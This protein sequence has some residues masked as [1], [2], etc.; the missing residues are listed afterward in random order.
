MGAVVF[1]DLCLAVAATAASL[2]L[3]PWRAVGEGGP[4]WSWLAVWA[5][6]PLLWGIDRYAASP[7]AQPM[8]G[9]ALL[10]LM[11][12]WP[13]AVLSLWPAALVTL[14]AGDLSPAEAL[15]RLVWLGVVPST[16]M[17]AIGAA[18]RRW[19]PHHLFIYILGRG[20]F[21]AFLACVVSALMMLAL[22][23]APVSGE[24]VTARVLTAFGEAFI[25]GMFTAILV[26]F[27]PQWLATYADRL[28]LPPPPAPPHP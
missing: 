14:L 9:L 11:A 19:L 22:Q 20:F 25:S 17:L 8:S 28:Y 4:P 10:T 18:L 3:R 16:F 12:G 6:T 21:G 7:L 15:H 2:W 5:F 23:A 1:I 24:F 26:A 13:L 27:R